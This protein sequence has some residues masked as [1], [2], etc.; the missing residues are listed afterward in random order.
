MTRP[1]DPDPVA[2]LYLNVPPRVGSMAD[3]VEKVL[4]SV[5]RPLE[6]EQWLAV[7]ALTSL[8]ADGMPAALEGA[9]I[10]ARQNLKTYVLE[11]IVLTKLLEPLGPRERRLIIWS[12]HLFDTAQESFKNFDELFAGWPHMS[13]RVKKVWRGNGEEEIDL[14]GNRRLKFK[15]RSK[16][17]GRGLSGDTVVLD[18][19][20]ALQPGHM[21]ALLPTLSTR[22]RAH[23][24]YGSSAGL[25]DSEVLRGVRD[26]GRSGGRGAPA[27]I[28]FA[29][30]VTSCADEE[31][32]HVPDT[33]GCALDREDLVIM[34]NPAARTGRITMDYLRSERLALP[35]DEFMRERLGWWDEPGQLDRKLRPEDWT[36]TGVE[37]RPELT[38]PPAFF[39]TI[40]ASGDACI[41]SSAFTAAGQPHVEL[42]DHRDGST[43]LA[44]RLAELDEQWPGAVFGAGKAGPVAGMVADGR[45][46]VE[47][48]LLT[49]AEMAQGC[50][51]HERLSR[52]RGYTHS[53]DA[54]VDSSLAGAQWKPAGD[55]L[56]LWDWRTSTNLAPIAAETGA[57]RLAELHKDDAYNP[58]DSVI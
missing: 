17:G 7:D 31:C 26:R 56:W 4:A 52:E 32:R 29:S 3:K 50:A 41:A 39:I 54:G 6:A 35:P 46:P 14:H 21:G 15:A 2:P 33:P 28:E 1:G 9:V 34:A 55:G 22:R 45:L 47:V 43:W 11:G 19:A 8:R 40:G 10:S 57:L 38:S 27:Y 44:D 37:D 20:F 18:E 23:V 53:K 42:A 49:P 48:E 12:A 24:L 16:S 30:P 5:E 58:L 36:A 13:K 51:H 25:A